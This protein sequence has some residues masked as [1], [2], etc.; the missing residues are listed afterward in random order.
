LKGLRAFEAVSRLGGFQ[1]A[2]NELNVTRSA[3]SHQIRS[4]EGTVGFAL[5]VRD[6]RPARLTDAGQAYFPVVRDAFDRIEQSTRA[7]ADDRGDDEL[8]I[9][10]YVTVALKW[11]IPRLHDF[12]QR[13]PEMR[14]RLSTSYVDWDFDREHADVGFIL[15]RRKVSGLHYRPMFRARLAPVCSPKLTAATGG[16]MRVAD[17]RDHTV[18][19][20]Y[21]AEEDW[22]T[23]LAAAGAP[24][25]M[26]SDRIAFDSYVLA[27]QAAEDGHGVAMT[28]GPFAK[29]ELRSGRLVKPFDFTVQHAHWWELVCAGKD[30]GKPKIRKFETWLAEQVRNDP[31]I[32]EHS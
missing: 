23:W 28:L 4:L 12:E 13:H 25:I 9:Q 15:A 22:Q 2:A 8:V 16:R 31:E 26:P 5:F 17:L 18:L 3:I 21:T 19:H 24:D 20:V 11:L 27:Q 30:R 7:L 6:T 32:E 29:D 14:V 10:V 1:Q